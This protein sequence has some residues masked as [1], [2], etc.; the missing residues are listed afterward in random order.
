MLAMLNPS[1]DHTNTSLLLVDIDQDDAIFSEDDEASLSESRPS[2]E[3]EDGHDDDDRFDQVGMSSLSSMSMFMSSLVGLRAEDVSI[4]LQAD[5][6]KP[7]DLPP[8]APIG[9]FSNANSNSSK[10]K[11]RNKI[12]RWESTPKSVGKSPRSPKSVVPADLSWKRPRAMRRLP[13]TSSASCNSSVSTSGSSLTS[14][15][16]GSSRKADMPILLPKRTD[17]S[18]SLTINAKRPQRLDSS[19]NLFSESSSRSGS[20]SVKSG[21]STQQVEVSPQDHVKEERTQALVRNDSMDLR[22]LLEGA[23]ETI[24]ED[25]KNIGNSQNPSGRTLSGSSGHQEGGVFLKIPDKMLASDRSLW[26]SA[27]TMTASFRTMQSSRSLMSHYSSKSIALEQSSRS[28]FWQAEEEATSPPMRL[29]RRSDSTDD[30]FRTKNSTNS[31]FQSNASARPVRRPVR[32]TS[33]RNMPL[34]D[35]TL[36]TELASNEAVV[37]RSSITST[38]AATIVAA[39]ICSETGRAKVTDSPP[40]QPR[41]L[42]GQRQQ[43]PPAQ[44]PESM[45]PSFRLIRSLSDQTLI[46]KEIIGE[47]EIG[48]A[49]DRSLPKRSLSDSQIFKEVNEELACE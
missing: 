41:R 38:S 29:P 28:L 31:P 3:D 48:D 42:R 5:N 7:R 10:H 44:R 25:I 2:E 12:S 49:A 40:Q 26:S 30:P 39:N 37:T 23:D 6:A 15:S 46:W 1:S 16:N 14:R 21:S 8:P 34:C 43:K 32:S 45:M 18:R 17:S 9:T 35:N 33:N 20:S 27:S 4:N 19:G 11:N 22:V 36:D 24:D 47:E 13:G